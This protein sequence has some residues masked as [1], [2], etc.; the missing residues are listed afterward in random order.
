MPIALQPFRQR[1]KFRPFQA[2]VLHIAVQNLGITFGCDPPQVMRQKWSRDVNSL[3]SSTGF[4]I[5][6]PGRQKWL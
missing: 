6:V 5:F 2:Q 1:S 3:T 4:E